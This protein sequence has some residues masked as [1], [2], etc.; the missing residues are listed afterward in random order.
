MCNFW[1]IKKDWSGW[2]SSNGFN[3]NK[4]GDNTAKNNNRKLETIRNNS[5]LFVLSFKN[6]NN[7][8]SARNSNITVY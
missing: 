7:D 4:T 6:G 8:Y 5:R 3:T 1:N 2:R